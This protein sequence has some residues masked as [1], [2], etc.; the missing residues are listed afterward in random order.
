MYW[1]FFYILGTEYKHILGV[2][3]NEGLYVHVHIILKL[4]ICQK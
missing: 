4:V 3:M 1:L 2:S